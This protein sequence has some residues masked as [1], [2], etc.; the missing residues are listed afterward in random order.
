MRSELAT[1]LSIKPGRE[2]GLIVLDEI[3]KRSSVID[4]L[5]EFGYTWAESAMDVLKESMSFVVVTPQN[6]KE[7]YDV[8][9]QYGTGQVEI[10][11]SEDMESEVYTPEYREDAH[12]YVI[13]AEDLAEMQRRYNIL[14]LVGPT[15]RV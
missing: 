8:L 15:I 10:F 3:E 2:I 9:V 6:V 11:R 4:D 5:T 12:Y 13:S 14:G 1:A 7:M